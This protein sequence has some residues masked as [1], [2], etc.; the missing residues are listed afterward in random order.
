MVAIFLISCSPQKKADETT[1]NH[2]ENNKVNIPGKKETRKTADKQIHLFLRD[3]AKGKKTNNEIAINKANDQLPKVG[4][5]KR[6]YKAHKQYV[7]AEFC[8][9]QHRPQLNSQIAFTDASYKFY[10]KLLLIGDL[11]NTGQTFALVGYSTS[12]SIV[13]IHVLKKV[14]N[15]FKPF[16]ETSTKNPHTLGA[17]HHHIIDFIDYNGDKIKDLKVMTDLRMMHTTE[18]SQ[19]WIYQDSRLLLI[20]EYKNISNGQYNPVDRKI[21][22]YVSI[23][24]GDL[25]MLFKVYQWNQNKLSLEK[26]IRCDCCTKTTCDIYINGQE[27]P[28]KATMDTAHNFIPKFWWASLKPKL[29]NY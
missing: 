6:T 15:E 2:K 25:H 26:N 10:R 9:F 27:K 8:K 5:Y 1:A 4:S 20:P 24:C 19:L 28:V 29:H 18:R 23:G 3:C 13:K 11:F 22:S 12:D 21:Y 14:K 17:P 16:F 7:W